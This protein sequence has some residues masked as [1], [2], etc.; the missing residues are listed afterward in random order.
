MGRSANFQRMQSGEVVTPTASVNGKRVPGQ[1][2]NTND[3]TGELALNNTLGTIWDDVAQAAAIEI[4]V[5]PDVEEG[6]EDSV[7]IVA[8]GDGITLDSD[9]T[10]VLMS[11]DDISTTDTDVNELIFVCKRLTYTNGVITGGTI[12]YSNK[13]N[14]TEN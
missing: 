9:F 10:W 7:R 14:P 8:N 11:S 6:G 5:G 12:M 3:F 13:L 2:E 1:V 4:S